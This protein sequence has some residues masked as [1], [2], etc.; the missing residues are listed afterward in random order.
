MIPAIW[1]SGKGKTMKTIRS[2]VV[3]GYGDEQAKHRGFLQQGS[4]AGNTI[5]RDRYHYTFVQ[6]HRRYYT[7]RELYCKLGTL[8]DDDV[9]L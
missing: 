8:G 4:Y 2:V 1:Y 9:S 3:M 6:I 5:V 7:K